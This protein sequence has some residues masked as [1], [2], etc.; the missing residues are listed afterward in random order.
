MIQ[1]NKVKTQN[2][3]K[4]YVLIFGCARKKKEQFFQ[5]VKGESGSGKKK[6][7]KVTDV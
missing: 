5:L 3:K 1:L 2:Q 6:G 4:F 7:E